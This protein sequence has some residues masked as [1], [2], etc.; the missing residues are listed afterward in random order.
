[1][2]YSQK[3]AGVGRC[4]GGWGASHHCDESLG[5]GS[6]FKMGYGRG[7]VQGKDGVWSW[8]GSGERVENRT[9]LVENRTCLPG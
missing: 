4:W 8:S 7:V 3:L 9:C 1:M 5:V 6:W 2:V